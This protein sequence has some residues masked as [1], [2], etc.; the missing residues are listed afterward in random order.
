MHFKS[1]FASEAMTIEEAKQ[2]M[3]S[4]IFGALSRDLDRHS[5]RNSG[6]L[7]FLESNKNGLEKLKRKQEADMSNIRK[8]TN[9]KIKTSEKNLEKKIITKVEKQI[10]KS[11]KQTVTKLTAVVKTTEKRLDEKN[12][13]IRD[14][15]ASNR[16]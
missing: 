13:K 14:E 10:K 16:G 11:S 12:K 2:K 4:I 15:V 1:Y 9:K 7:K 3:D 5:L 6:M 8:S